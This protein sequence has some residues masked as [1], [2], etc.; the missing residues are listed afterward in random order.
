MKPFTLPQ[1][2]ENEVRAYLFLRLC[3]ALS[4]LNLVAW[5]ILWRT[6]NLWL[7]EFAWTNY[8][9]V[10]VFGYL[11]WKRTK[12]PFLSRSAR[13]FIVLNTLLVLTV[14]LLIS[15]ISSSHVVLIFMTIVALAAFG[16]RRTR[17]RK[18]IR[19]HT[20]DQPTWFDPRSP[21]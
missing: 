4:L 3:R 20:P 16:Y 1:E 19:P 17:R 2:I 13:K 9:G 18:K 8:L 5:L 21:G 15:D 6:K 12:L 7:S 11:A 14:I 10:L